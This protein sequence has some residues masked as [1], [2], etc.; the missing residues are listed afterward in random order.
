MKVDDRLESLSDYKKLFC[1]LFSAP[2]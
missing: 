1:R 2:R